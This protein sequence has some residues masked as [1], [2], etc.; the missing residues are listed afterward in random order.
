M[1]FHVLSQHHWESCEG[2]RQAR[3]EDVPP[4]VE[5]QKWIEG[6]DKVKVLGAYGYQ[7]EHRNYAI[8]EADSYAEVQALFRGHLRRGH[9]EVLPVNDMIA[10][11]K[12][13]GESGK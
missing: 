1:I 5:R 4:L 2:T 12:G 3:G 11:R 9:V 10:Q 7:T 13:F 8:V 6:N